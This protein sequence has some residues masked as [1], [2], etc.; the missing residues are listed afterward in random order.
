MEVRLDESTWDA[1]RALS[2]CDDA[3]CYR[4]ICA[5]EREAGE[6]DERQHWALPHHYPGKEA[7]AA[8]VAA[9]RQ[10]FAQTQGLQNRE[11][12]RRHLFETHRLPSD[13]ASGDPDGDFRDRRE[14]LVRAVFPGT[15]VRVG[16]EDDKPLLHVTFARF[17]EWTEIDSVFE[18][19]F[20]ERVAPGAFTESF[21]TLT[22]KPLFQHGRDPELGDKVLAAPVRAWEDDEGGHLEGPLFPSV[23]PLIVDGLRAG[24]YGASF[25]FSVNG[26]DVNRRPGRSDHNPEGL[27]ERTITAAVVP[28]AGPVTFPAYAGATA[29]V[30]SLTDELT[31]ATFTTDPK[32]LAAVIGYIRGTDEPVAPP[33]SP[34]QTAA[35]VPERKFRSREDYLSW[36]SKS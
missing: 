9:A 19:R 12:A 36:L 23:P 13:E 20:M 34:K 29:G 5:G 17:N 18:G 4:S 11:A 35:A 7:N 31:F 8:G 2:S 24:A 6:P 22:P 27:P 21:E 32:R 33:A 15:E 3:A 16:S 25:R 10:R 30:R 26:E 14:D 28:E 1:N